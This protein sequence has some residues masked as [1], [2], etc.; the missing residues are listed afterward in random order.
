MKEKQ[1]KKKNG[2][3]FVLKMRKSFFKK[4]DKGDQTK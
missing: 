2:E 3:D 4:D 1:K